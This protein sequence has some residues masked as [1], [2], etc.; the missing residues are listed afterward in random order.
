[1]APVVNFR[2]VAV[3]APVFTEVG[4]ISPNVNAIA[5]AVVG[6]VTT[7]DTPAFVVTET[8]VIPPLAGT[9]QVPSL[10]RNDPTAAVPFPAKAVVGMVFAPNNPARR[11]PVILEAFNEPF[12]VV[13]VMS[14]PL[15]EPVVLI[16]L[17]EMAPKPRVMVEVGNTFDTVAVIPSFGITATNERPLPP[18][19]PASAQLKLPL[20]LEL[21]T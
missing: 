5:G 15:M 17:G 2:P 3:I 20:P 1:M 4:V 6:L 12:N 13:P 7:P 10:R 9:A 14:P 21:K 16:E 11:V 8:L 18:T 19:E